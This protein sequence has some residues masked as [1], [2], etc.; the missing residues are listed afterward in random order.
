MFNIN[1]KE[2]TVM[3]TTHPAKVT[4]NVVFTLLSQFLLYIYIYTYP[5]KGFW[6]KKNSDPV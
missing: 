4:I 1:L 6:E 2:K 5:S 3:G